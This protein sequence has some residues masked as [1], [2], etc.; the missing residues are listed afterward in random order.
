MICRIGI[1]SPFPISV[2][3]YI[4]EFSVEE[5]KVQFLYE[6]TFYSYLD[7]EC[8]YSGRFTYKGVFYLKKFGSCNGYS[9][10]LVTLFVQL[11]ICKGLTF[12]VIIFTFS[13]INSMN[14]ENK[15]HT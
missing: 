7:H 1:Q 2:I 9:W 11:K 12:E 14:P 5:H 8:V 3:Q 6:D 13:T 10:F 4:L 15:K